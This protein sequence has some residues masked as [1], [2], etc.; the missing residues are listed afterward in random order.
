LIN[1]KRGKT[2]IIRVRSEKRGSITPDPTGMS[3]VN[4]ATLW[5]KSGNLDEM[6]KLLE[7]HVSPKLAQSRAQVAHAYNP[8]YSGG[9]DQ[10]DLGSEP[11]WAN[12]SVRPYLEK[13]F[14]KI[15]LV[16]WLK[17]RALSLSPNIAKKKKRKKKKK[18]TGPRRNRKSE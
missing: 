16:E 7:R 6:E 3:R 1:N 5:N 11:A 4:Q 10:E 9:R 17:V 14:T 8:S 18:E 13:P 2:Q 12:T 15:G